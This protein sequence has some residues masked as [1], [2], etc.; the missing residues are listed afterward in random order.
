[1]YV[2]A[3][4]KCEIDVCSVWSELPRP[5]QIAHC[6]NELLR[7]G[8]LN[9]KSIKV[10]RNVLRSVHEHPSLSLD[11]CWC[12]FC[13]LCAL[14]LYHLYPSWAII[15]WLVAEQWAGTVMRDA[16]GNTQQTDV[17]DVSLGGRWA[18]SDVFRYPKWR[19]S[20]LER[21]CKVHGCFLLQ[22]AQ[23]QLP[24]LVRGDKRRWTDTSIASNTDW[25]YVLHVKSPWFTDSRYIA[26]IS[27]DLV[28]ST[29]GFIWFYLWVLLDFIDGSCLIP[30]V[31]RTRAFRWMSLQLSA[32]SAQSGW[33]LNDHRGQWK[34]EV[35][36]RAARSLQKVWN[37]GSAKKE[38]QFDGHFARFLASLARMHLVQESLV[39]AEAVGISN[40]PTA[41]VHH[42]DSTN[43]HQIWRFSQIRNSTVESTWKISTSWSHG[44]TTWASLSCRMLRFRPRTSMIQ[45]FTKFV[46]GPRSNFWSRSDRHWLIDTNWLKCLKDAVRSVWH[47][48]WLRGRWMTQCCTLAALSSVTPTW[49]RCSDAL[50]SSSVTQPGIALQG[51]AVTLQRL[52]EASPSRDL[53]TS[54]NDRLLNV[55]R[56]FLD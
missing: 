19:K 18:A 30:S 45:R 10:T 23:L 40:Q 7:R 50:E 16:G 24:R 17:K 26:D 35:V 44:E 46:S 54:R 37:F 21:F 20:P 9:H 27:I 49:V 47:W 51:L 12:D 14:C 15:R 29:D 6:D 32:Q 48:R 36:H 25:T 11:W 2:A 28:D 33:V 53:V 8:R 4:V 52:N 55:D 38:S 3:D 34:L 41:K 31:K 43:D 22:V 42:S 5:A 1:M 13:V 56:E 39:F